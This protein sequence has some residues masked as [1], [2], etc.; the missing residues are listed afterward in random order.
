MDFAA[1]VTFAPQLSLTREAISRGIARLGERI[2]ELRNFDTNSVPKGN[3]PQL[4]ALSTAI[5]DTLDRCFGEGTARFSR[6]VDATDLQ[7]RAFVFYDGYPQRQHYIEGS[8]KNIEA[9]IALLSEAQRVLREDLDDIGEPAIVPRVRTFEG[10]RR[11]FVVHGHDEGAREAVAQ[12]LERLGLQPIILNEQANRG[13]TIIEKVEQ[14][15]SADFAVVLL[16]PDDEG[17]PKGGEFKP[18]PRQNVLLELGYFIAKLGR[19]RVCTLMKG[20]LEIP[21]D[22]AGVVWE[23]MD[24][25]DWKSALGRELEAAGYDIDWNKVM[26]RKS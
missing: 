26:S 8:A 9:S 1:V 7:F 11:I 17:G 12:F 14:E 20:T 16:T 13:R 22:F 24:G 2:E 19:E 10:S 15:S 21:S 18:R 25:S 6:F 5:R 23:S 4:A 3:S